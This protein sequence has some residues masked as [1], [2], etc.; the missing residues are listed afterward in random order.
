M[1]SVNK[2]ILVGNLTRDPQLSYLPSHTAA[3]DFGLATSRKWKGQYGQQKEEVCFVDVVA[4]GKTAET[5]AQYL[6]KGN[7]VYIEGRLKFEQWKAQDGSNRSKLRVLVDSFQFL[8]NG[9]KQN[10][11]QPR[12]TQQPGSEN[13]DYDPNYVPSGEDEIPF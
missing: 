2:V 7:L 10:S 3:V 1:A 8:P 13:P 5:L 9:D 11:Q 4:F 12:P 6:K